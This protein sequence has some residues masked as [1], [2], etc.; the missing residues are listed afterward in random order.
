MEENPG[1]FV[2]S[3]FSVLDP[4]YVPDSLTALQLRFSIKTF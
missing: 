3:G 4:V 1:T 2:V